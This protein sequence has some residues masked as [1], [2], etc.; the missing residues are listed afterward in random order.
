MTKTP[1]GNGAKGKGE[2]KQCEICE[3]WITKGNFNRHVQTIHKKVKGYSCNECDR[4]FTTKFNLTK[5]LTFVHL[6]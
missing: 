4:S 2:K 5:H 1:K 6:S 3:E